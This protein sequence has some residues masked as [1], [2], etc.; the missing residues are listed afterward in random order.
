MVG[1]GTT[2][3]SQYTSRPTNSNMKRTLNFIY[4]KNGNYNSSSAGNS[5]KHYLC[6]G[7]K[8]S[9]ERKVKKPDLYIYAGPT[10]VTKLS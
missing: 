3:D 1:W 4:N 10:S 2:S 7:I 6:I 9:L 8:N 5:F